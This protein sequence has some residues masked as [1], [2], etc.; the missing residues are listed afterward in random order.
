MFNL[1]YYVGKK[2]QD[3]LYEFAVEGPQKSYPYGEINVKRLQ[4]RENANSS[5]F[6]LIW[7]QLKNNETI[8]ASARISINKFD[9]YIKYDVELNAVPIKK[10][11][12]SKNVV[13][14]WYLLDGFDTGNRL[15]TDS[16][17]LSMQE[18]RLFARKEYTY[19]PTNNSVSAN[20]YPVTS[21]IAVRDQNTTNANYSGK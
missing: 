3:G 20:Y 19:T 4:R 1:R 8:R 15:W 11:K 13:V 21:A 6:V 12:T 9:P 18:K 10:D 7:E 16:N 17:G 2:K 14:D 5:E